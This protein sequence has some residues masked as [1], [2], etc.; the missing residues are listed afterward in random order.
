MRPA[1]PKTAASVSPT[2]VPTGWRREWR[3]DAVTITVDVGVNM[4]VRMVCE[5]KKDEV[6]LKG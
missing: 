6:A 4:E 3:V 2:M 5:G 1:T